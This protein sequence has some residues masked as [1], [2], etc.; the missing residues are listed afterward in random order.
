MMEPREIEDEGHE[1]II[2]RV[3]AIDVAKASGMVCVRV[4]H[5]SRPGRRVSRVWEV[6]ATTGAVTGLGDHLACQGT[7][8][9]IPDRMPSDYTWAD[10]SGAPGR[11]LR[12][13]RRG[14]GYRHGPGVPDVA[15]VVAD[16]PV[17]GEE[18]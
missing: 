15:A 5:K 16:C 9:G 12:G 3:A 14:W 6:A 7:G 2:E 8:E 1:R 10:D 11:S 13:G 18:A 4:P 17:G